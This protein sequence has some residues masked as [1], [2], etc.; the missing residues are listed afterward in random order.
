M[1][2]GKP[3]KITRPDL[4]VNFF[5]HFLLEKIAKRR[6]I[7]SRTLDYRDKFPNSSL[8]WEPT[9]ARDSAYVTAQ[10]A[11]IRV[12]LKLCFKKSYKMYYY[13]SLARCFRVEDSKECI[14]EV[15]GFWNLYIFICWF[16]CCIESFCP[17]RVIFSTWKRRSIPTSMFLRFEKIKKKTCHI[18]FNL[19]YK[20]EAYGRQ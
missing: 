10:F 12:Q 9:L 6:G 17:S 13:L 19:N 8:Y 7:K 2:G 4:F 11:A 20:Y 15:T 16:V 14:I 1:L 5:N 18:H 3:F